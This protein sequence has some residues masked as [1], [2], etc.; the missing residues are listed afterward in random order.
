MPS[1]ILCGVA[2]ACRAG[3]LF[4]VVALSLAAAGCMA[5]SRGTP[6]A[7]SGTAAVPV[8]DQ[9][10]SAAC[11]VKEIKTAIVGFF[12]SWNR[13]DPVAFSRLFDAGSIF[14]FAGKHQDT[15]KQGIN[16]YTEVGGR[17]MIVAL[18]ERQ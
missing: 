4:A 6:A 2:A 14:A 8:I 9:A 17:S 18:A 11:S 15:I 5:S 10:Q 3:Q 12:A 7:P 13:R 16:G 1:G